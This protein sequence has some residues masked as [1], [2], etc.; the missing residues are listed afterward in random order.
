MP[1]QT[2]I[3]GY[4]LILTLVSMGTLGESQEVADSQ[5][6]AVAAGAPSL[7]CGGAAGVRFNLEPRPDPLPQDGTAVDF[8]PGAG[9]AGADLVVGAANDMRLLTAGSGVAPD[10]RGVFGMTSQTGFYVHRSGS[11]P[12][13]CSPD[14][15]GGLAPVP[16]PISGNAMVGVGY[17]AVAAY[18]PGQSFFIADTRVGEGE[19]G[20]SAIGVFRTTAANL[21]DPSVCPDGTLSQSDSEQCWPVRALVNLSSTLSRTN[22]SPSLSV[23]ERPLASG[24]GAGDVYVSATQFQGSARVFLAACKND[25]SACSAP[26]VVSDTDTAGTSNVAVRPDGGVTVTY[27]AN[28]TGGFGNPTAVRI[29]YVACQPGGAPA[30]PSCSPPRLVFSESHAIPFIPSNPQTGLHSNRFVLQTFPKHAHRMDVNGIETYVVWDRC[31]VSTAIPYPGL[32]FV[33]KCADADI[34]L[35]ASADNG[36]SWSYAPLDVDAQDQFQPWIAVDR[37]SNTVHIAYYTS[38]ADTLFQHRPRVALRQI[39][40]GGSTPDPPLKL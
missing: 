32:T 39:P 19:A 17:P 18:P 21:D 16:S 40:P 11:D 27:T 14:L 35:A 24:A 26:V 33:N 22:S 3:L 15:E 31:R 4:S 29:K 37:A 1:M 36:Q 34:L 12:N 2:R 25:L 28:V 10:F 30:P 38:A 7:P 6:A 20:D 5:V 13:P 8:L 23:D 9:L